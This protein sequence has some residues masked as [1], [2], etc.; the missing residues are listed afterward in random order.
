MARTRRTTT[1]H[2]IVAAGRYRGREVVTG[3]Y[4]TW[5]A[6][7]SSSR[8]YAAPAIGLV[9]AGRMTAVYTPR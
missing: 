3:R 1:R 4:A 6:V 5:P 9:P 8:Q 7:R 2:V